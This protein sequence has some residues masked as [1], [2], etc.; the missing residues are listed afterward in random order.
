MSASMFRFPCL[1]AF[2]IV[3]IAMPGRAQNLAVDVAN[4]REDLR[5]LSQRVGELTLRVEQLKRENAALRSQTSG[6]AQTYATVAQLNESVAD[7]N[8]TIKSVA[9]AT[10]S[11]T[12][13]QVSGQIE[14]LAKQT[15]AAIDSLAKGMSQRAAVSAPNFSGD[16][17]KEGTTYT[18]QKG[19]TLSGI[20]SR[21]GA[22]LQDIINAN[23]IVDPTRLQAGQVLFIPGGK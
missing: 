18:V 14:A 6:A 17:P 15:N 7:L 16:Y 9:V 2:G 11:D 22:K 20:A 12:L 13:Q 10:K 23:K 21:T 8:R 3:A 4:M 19:D 1:L 5:V